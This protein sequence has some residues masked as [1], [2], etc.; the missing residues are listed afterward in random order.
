LGIISTTA[1]TRKILIQEN[2]NGYY[3]RANQFVF[4]MNPGV[5]TTPQQP[6]GRT[7][8]VAIYANRFGRPLANTL[9]DIALMPSLVASAYT[10]G[11]LGTG[12]SSG[13]VNMS[14]PATAIDFPSQ[15]TTDNNGIARFTLTASDPG[16]P[17]GY[18]DG[19]IY[20]LKYRFSDPDINECYVQSP[21]DVISIQIYSQEP[22]IEEITW[23]NFVKTTLGL[24]G[25]LYPVMGFLDLEKEQGVID[26]ADKIY[27]AINRD[28]EQGN[29]MPVTRDLSAS[30]LA[31]LNTWL[32]KHVKQSGSK[33]SAFAKPGSKK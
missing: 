17:R 5:A 33:K 20:F 14:V 25:K 31:L 3:L 15:A 27:N 19:Q 16:N 11:T 9:I 6:R 32:L 24:Y 10:D 18:I 26:N 7:Q 2:A 4:R 8:E 22:D 21:D 12:G 13:L 30:R 28:F 1:S 29:L 23:E